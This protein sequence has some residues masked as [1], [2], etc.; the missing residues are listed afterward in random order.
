MSSTSTGGWARCLGALVVL[1][2][3]G[4]PG[5][6][7]E[8]GG[9]DVPLLPG[10]KAPLALPSTEQL[11]QAAAKLS[12]AAKRQGMEEAAATLASMRRSGASA[13][14]PVSGVRLVAYAAH[15]EAALRLVRGS[16]ETLP[17]TWALD[18]RALTAHGERCRL[19]AMLLERRAK[20][21]GEVAF[22]AAFGRL[23]HAWSIALAGDYVNAPRLAAAGATLEALPDAQRIEDARWAAFLRGLAYPAAADPSVGGW[24]DA[25]TKRLEARGIGEQPLRLLGVARALGKAMRAADMEEKGAAAALTQALTPLA[26]PEALP[27]TDTHL[28]GL[29]NHALTRARSLKLPLKLEYRTRRALTASGLLELALPIGCGWVESGRRSD[30]DDGCWI[31]DRD[32]RDHVTLQVWKYS[33]STDYVDDD[34]KVIGGDNVGGRLKSFFEADKASL[35]KVKRATAAV[36]RLSRGVPDSRGYEVRGEDEV[37]LMH[38]FREWYYKSEVRRSVINISMRRKGIVLEPDPELEA[39][40]ESMVEVGARP[41]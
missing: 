6:W 18:P 22:A 1:V 9:E 15:P 40:L 21:E 17:E 13:A 4:A 34:G 24:V 20:V 2:V 25:Q 39:I 29:Y 31:R 19:L 7:P 30:Q 5:A 27:A 14:A 32:I 16:F 11:E 26:A 36:G 35:R 41:K 10:E 28:V 23:V 37:G 33:T 3:S 8:E 12:E 38:W